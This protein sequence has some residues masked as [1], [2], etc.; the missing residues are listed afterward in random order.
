[1]TG[2][3]NPELAARDA[4]WFARRARNA[5]RRPL[6]MVIAGGSAFLVTLVVLLI[7]PRQGNNSAS[8]I[9]VLTSEKGDT[10][11]LIVLQERARLALSTAE[12]ALAAAR[13]RTLRPPPPPPT[14]TLPPELIARRDS[15]R[16]ASAALAA[17]IERVENAPLPASYRALGEM[18][19]LAG[20]ARVPVLLDSLAEVER[21]REEFGAVG[22]VDP[23]FV[24]LTSRATA[25]GRS[26][27]A[28]AEARRA[29]AQQE[30]IR[31]RPPPPPPPV[32]VALVDTTPIV[33]RRDA[34]VTMLDT[35]SRRL[36][37]IR[38][39]NADI[40][41]RVE[42]IRAAANVEIPP[43][44]LLA[45]AL[46]LAAVA[47]FGAAL[48]AEMRRSRIADP[49]EAEEVTGLRVLTVV[50]P[51][52]AQP[53][54]TRRRADQDISPL[55]DAT[56]NAYRL[57]YLH[58]AGY[59]P[60]V[61]LMTVSGEDPAI[62]AT[63]AANL[64][65]ASTYDAR[66]TLLVD[67]ELSACAVSSILGVRAEPGFGDVLAGR[68]D[69]TEAVIPAIIGRERALDVI[70]SGLC[71][72]PPAGFNPAPTR[73]SLARIARRYDLVVLVMAR[74]DIQRG[75]G[76]VLPAPDVIY[77]AQL[78]VTTIAALRAGTK[79]LRGA[80]ARIRGLVLWNADVPL[81]QSKDLL[82]ARS[83]L[84]NDAP[85]SAG[86]AGR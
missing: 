72:E 20:D 16:R 34:A 74:R 36:A 82:A 47:G 64:A 67:A 15:L 7:I 1:M 65:A 43:L 19:E 9:A 4:T 77:C 23:I 80:G 58:I 35:S 75:D 42:A 84:T 60:R 27:Q 30:L 62:T 5:L 33:A 78:G 45:A 12:D 46:V 24:A 28:V 21:E 49:E 70:P 63:V 3:W 69:W 37:E 55:L 17:M 26:I 85:L 31:L 61:S 83:A 29:T 59:V 41:Q 38:Q 66:S 73:H 54:R 32:V 68:V 44:T 18:P 86:R 56:S 11:P 53:E 22:G 50:L 76:G 48:T 51:K 10:T 57:L 52:G 79:A 81:I 25:I 40:D 6:L 71:G 39:V 13:S 14:D 8:R 2:E